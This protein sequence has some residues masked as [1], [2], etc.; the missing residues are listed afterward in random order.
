MKARVVE[1]VTMGGEELVHI[2]FLPPNEALNRT[3]C[4]LLPTNLIII[5]S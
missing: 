4:M 3:R 5:D 1:N 2:Q